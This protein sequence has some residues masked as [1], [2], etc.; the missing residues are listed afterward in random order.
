MPSRRELAQPSCLSA[1]EQER[2]L[3]SG[4]VI[5]QQGE[6][7][8][9]IAR[10]CCIGSDLC[11]VAGLRGFR[12]RLPGDV[13]KGGCQQRR[14]PLRHRSDALRRGHARAR[15]KIRPTARLTRRPSW[16]LQGRRLRPGQGRGRRSAEG[17]QQ[18]HRRPGQ[19]SR[20]RQ[21]RDR[22]RRARRKTTTA[23]GAA[24]PSRT[25]SP[26]RW[27][28]TTRATSFSRPRRNRSHN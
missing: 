26:A 6:N 1:V 5:P 28:S 21:R 2:R 3:A 12:R 18:L 20:D 4:P 7:N 16:G 19:G 15:D 25:A 9:T 13:D 17:R 24:W 23:C 27:P 11:G 22:D 14:C 10:G 8:E